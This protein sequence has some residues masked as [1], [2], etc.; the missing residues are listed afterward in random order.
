MSLKF[1]S[2]WVRIFVSPKLNFSSIR[3]AELGFAAA[4]GSDFVIM[5]T[6]E[7]DEEDQ[8]NTQKPGVLISMGANAQGQ[9][10]DATAKNQW[11][12][13]FLNKDGPDLTPVA[14][15]SALATLREY[16]LTAAYC[17]SPT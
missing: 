12:P 16:E 14:L 11:V 9:L 7:G 5:T 2:I 1:L 6:K 8:F 10:G 13:Q 3:V 15:I 17:F 4:C